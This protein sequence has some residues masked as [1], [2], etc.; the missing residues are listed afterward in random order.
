MG[1]LCGCTHPAAGSTAC[2]SMFSV[3]SCCCM[4]FA[5][6]LAQSAC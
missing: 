2:V 5:G 3:S 6:L 4:L 1:K